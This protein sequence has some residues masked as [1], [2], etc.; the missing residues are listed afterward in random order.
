M[1]KG[2]LFLGMARGSVGDVT[3]THVDGEQVARARNR[4]PKN[5]KTAIQLL[6]RVVLKTS[7]SAYS[8][9]QDICNHSFQGAAE[10]TMSQAEFNKANIGWMR[11]KLSFEINSGD[12]EDIL[13]SGESNFAP[14]YSEGIEFNPYIV[15]AG[16]LTKVPVEWMGTLPTPAFGIPIDLGKAAPS[17]AEVV[18]ALGI[19]QADQLTF[20]NLSLDDTQDGGTC[21]GFDYCRVI[22]EPDSS[23]MDSAF[24]NGTAINNPNEKNKGDFK[25]TIQNASGSYY[26]TFVSSRYSNTAGLV[27]SVCAGT[28]ILSRWNGSVWARSPQTFA[29]RPYT[30]SAAGHL[31]F[32]HGTDYLSDAVYS[33][34]TDESS[35]LYLNQAGASG[36]GTVPGIT[37][38]LAS[39]TAGSTSV[40]R[41][42]VAQL[43]G[44]VAIS[45]TMTG[46]Q[47]GVVYTL[48][49]HEYT[50]EGPEPTP[51]KS[52]TFSG[53]SA[54]IPS[55]GYSDGQ[56]QVCLSADG[57]II[58][59]YCMLNFDNS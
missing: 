24:L 2:N 43:Q 52:A 20:L 1:S 34:M 30:L 25:F 44:S 8:L 7:S 17:Y 49:V 3:F 58:D 46:A 23:V 33:Y 22:M 37:G 59:T 5:P 42:G 51:A 50:P 28:V 13:A 56:W 10:G 39:V 57:E 6:Q 19:Q 40:A 26:L 21:N 38:T 45:A 32:D 12:P 53:N 35:T 14:R 54:S 41:N 55:Y 29:V 18:A 48:G 36:S 47:A 15:S 9:M 31:S 27:N 4:A 11:D 16:S